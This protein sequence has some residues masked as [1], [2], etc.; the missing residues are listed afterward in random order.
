[1]KIMNKQPH[2]T[3]GTVELRLFLLAPNSFVSKAPKIQSL[4]IDNQKQ[5]LAAVFNQEKTLS[6]HFYRK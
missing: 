4:S 1:M 5:Y 2:Y 6:G 3:Q